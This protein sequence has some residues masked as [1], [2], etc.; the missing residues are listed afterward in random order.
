MKVRLAAESAGLICVIDDCQLVATV[1]DLS[2]TI[3]LRSMVELE[4]LVRLNLKFRDCRIRSDMYYSI[5]VLVV[6]V[7][8]I[9]VFGVLAQILEI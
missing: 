9:R 1:G 8:G 4:A 2:Y 6:L 5:G 7:C 3:M